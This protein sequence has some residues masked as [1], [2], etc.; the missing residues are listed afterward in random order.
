LKLRNGPTAS[1]TACARAA[2][3]RPPADRAATDSKEGHADEKAANQ[4]RAVGRPGLGA[5]SQ[6]RLPVPGPPGN[7]PPPAVVQAREAEPDR[8]Q[9]EEGVVPGQGDQRLQ[10][11]ERQR[12]GMPQG[13]RRRDAQGR[14][15]RSRT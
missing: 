8:E 13:P 12:A 2:K 1:S 3:P 7:P 15:A 14:P 10:R 4:R 6:L 5:Q 11:D 9:V